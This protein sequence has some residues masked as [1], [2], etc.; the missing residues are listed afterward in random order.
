MKKIT[1]VLLM[2]VLV[3]GLVACGTENAKVSNDADTTNSEEVQETAKIKE[4]E[5][6]I[7]SMGEITIENIEKINEAK[8]AYDALSGEAK[9]KVSNYDV[10]QNALTQLEPLKEEKVNQLLSTMYYEEDRV[11]NM[12]FYT[13]N[14]VKHY[15]DGSWAAD[16]RCFVIPYIGMDDTSCWLRL[17]YNYT[18]DDW[19]FFKNVTFAVD[20]ERYYESFNYFDIVHDNGGGDVWEY[21]DVEVSDSDVE[22]LK[23][24]ANSTETIV[25][26]E[27]DDYSHD[28]VVSA[29][30]KQAI[31]DVI[32]VYELKK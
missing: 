12:K 9:S 15:S 10:L 20:N 28:F 24:I 1:A 5:E 27:G 8:S 19:V 16:I 7:G 3:F 13:P 18:G 21:I 30:D 14:V 2:F 17:I 32:T 22:L 26:F 6:K 23:K 31:K 29:D 11:Q 25:R 4:V